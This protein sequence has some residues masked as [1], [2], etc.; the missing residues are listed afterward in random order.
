MLETLFNRISADWRNMPAAEFMGFVKPKCQEI[1]PPEQLEKILAPLTSVTSAMP[2]TPANSSASTPSA[3]SS[4]STS[5][6][7]RKLKIKLGVDATGAN[8]HIG[9]IVPLVLLRQFQKAGH[10]IDFIIGDFTATIGDPSGRDSERKELTA[11]DVKKNAKGF[12][13]QIKPYINL[14]RGTFSSLSRTSSSARVHFNSKWLSK[15]KM[16]EMISYL[17][18]ISMS[19]ATQ[20][21]DFRKRLA[22]G[23]SVSLA[24]TI[25]GFLMGLDSVHL[26]SDI[27]VG[28]I[29]QLINFQQCRELMSSVGMVPETVLCVSLIEGTDGSGKKMS[30]SVGNTINLNASHE[31]K[32][33]KVM[34]IPDKLIFPWYVAF[35]DIHES[36]IEVLKKAIEAEPLEMKKQLGVLLIA[37]ETKS[38]KE[39]KLEREKFERKFAKKE[40]SEGDFVEV[41]AGE[42]L[43]ETLLPQFESKGELRRL[44]E[45]GAVK[46]AETENVLAMDSGVQR[47]MKV[48]VGKRGFFRV[49]G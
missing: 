29:D 43:F 31:D 22:A 21:D 37:L 36:E 17:Q 41:K 1:L 12:T 7:P 46:H 18:H 2:V 14:G 32:F 42:N 47:G 13:S 48:K 40:L 49:V 10:H 23:N 35:T 27:E 6:K 9:H 45:Q 16:S 4:F 26:K 20:R 38:L 25:Y 5:S 3:T 30:K 39:G 11:S 33:G 24:E 44:F 34:S 28:A 8:L 19:S 15:M